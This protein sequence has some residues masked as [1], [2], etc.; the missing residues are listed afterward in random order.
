MG[1]RRRRRV[2]PHAMRH[3]PVS[4][5]HRP[6]D[7]DPC[8][9]IVKGRTA[10]ANFSPRTQHANCTIV[11]PTRRCSHAS[12]YSLILGG[13]PSHRRGQ[14]DRRRTPVAQL[15]TRIHHYCYCPAD[16][17]IQTSAP[18]SR[19]TTALRP[20]SSNAALNTQERRFHTNHRDTSAPTLAIPYCQCA[21]RHPPRQIQGPPVC[22]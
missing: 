7:P 14:H 10:L 8:C 9:Q 11:I 5:S 13:T 16:R 15:E 22:L 12:R 20:R 2:S 17:S 6:R 1:G 21:S 18:G 3:A 4:V 19:R